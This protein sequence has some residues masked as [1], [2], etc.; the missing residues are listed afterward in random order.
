MR[1][2]LALSLLLVLPFATVA[3]A[4]NCAAAYV[5]VSVPGG[6][7]LYLQDRSTPPGVVVDH[8]LYMESNGVAGLQ[9]GGVSAILGGLDADDCL[10]ANPDTLIV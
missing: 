2:V 8:W 7:T 3:D 6:P 10:G 5:T 9:V 1:S 4:H